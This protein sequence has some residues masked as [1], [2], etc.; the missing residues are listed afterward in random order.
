MRNTKAPRAGSR[1]LWILL[2]LLILSSLGASLVQ[3]SFGD[4]EVKSITLPTQNGQWLVADLFR[5]RS[6]TATPRWRP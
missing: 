4:I 6:A 2:A 1:S 5:P 3:T